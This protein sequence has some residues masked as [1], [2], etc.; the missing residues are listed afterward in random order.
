VSTN[1]KPQK[2]PIITFQKTPSGYYT[3]EQRRPQL[4]GHFNLE[5]IHTATE[6]NGACP[7]RSHLCTAT[8][9]TTS[10]PQ[11]TTELI[12]SMLVTTLFRTGWWANLAQHRAVCCHERVEPPL[13]STLQD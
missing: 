6:R 2:K 10:L 11:S 3:P 1:G 8:T 5:Q 12:P 13:S 7:S 9:T 4:Y